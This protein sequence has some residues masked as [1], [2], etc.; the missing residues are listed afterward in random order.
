M[1]RSVRHTP[2][3]LTRTRISSGAG[4][5]TGRVS[6]R[7]GAVSTDAGVERTSAVNIVGGP[8]RAPQTPRA[9]SRPGAAGAPL[10]FSTGVAGPRHG[11]PTPS[12]GSRPE[13]SLG[14][15]AGQEFLRAAEV[16]GV[17]H[18]APEGEGV[19]AAP[20][21]LFERDNQLSRFVDGLLR[22]R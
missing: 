7:S 9:R 12:G 2:H 5:G 4:E 11:P 10:D 17:H 3:A 14:A 6:R 18:L 22:R 1:C 20:R 21:V 16:R 19:D 8:R 13:D 15:G